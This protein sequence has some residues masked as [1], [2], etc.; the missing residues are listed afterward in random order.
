MG[1]FIFKKK[2]LVNCNDFCNFVDEI[3]LCLIKK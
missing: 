1:N 2:D 3:L